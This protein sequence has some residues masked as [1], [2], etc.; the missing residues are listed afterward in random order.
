MNFKHGIRIKSTLMLLTMILSFLPSLLLAETTKNLAVF[1][2]LD[3]NA[4]A[5]YNKIVAEELPKIG[6]NSADPHH[7]VNDQY[8]SKY[9]STILDVLSFL[10]VVNDANVMP[11]FNIDPRLAGFAPFNMLIHKRLDENVT[12]VGHLTPEA[13]LDII[14]ISDKEVREKFIASFKPLNT[15]LDKEFGKDKKSYKTYTSL[16]KDNML[17]F[18]YKFE[19]PEDMDDF[20]DEFQ[21]KFE[22]S[23]INKEYL[24]AGF[25]DFKSTDEG[26][27]ALEAFDIF[28]GYSLCHLEYSYNMFDNKGARPDAGLFAPCTMYMYVK[29]DSDILVV[30]MPKL[31]NIMDTLG[32]KEASRVALVKKLD[33]EIPEILTAFGMK[34]VENVN[35]LKERPKEKFNPAAIAVA[36]AKTTEKI[37][38]PKSLPIVKKEEVVEPKKSVVVKKTVVEEK[39]EASK[40]ET[41]K[42]VVHIE[43]PKVPA[44]PKPL[45]LE[46]NGNTTSTVTNFDRS[47]K[48]SKRVPPN[49]LTSAERYG[50]DGKGTKL[51]QKQGNVGEVDKGRISAYLRAD[52]MDVKH[53]S[54]KLKSAGFEVLAEFPL[55]KKKELVSIVFTDDRLKKMASKTNRGFIGTLRLLVDPK[56]NQISIT[57]PLY[58]GK[59]MLQSDY[60]E[61][62]AK[63]ILASLVK[64]FPNARNSMDKLKYQLLPKYQFM[65]GMPYYNDMEV[66]ARGDDLLEKLEKKKNKKKVVFKFKLPNGSTLIGVKLSKRTSKFPKRIGTNN[67]GM[68]PY[69]ILIENGEAKIMEPKY[70][71]ALMYPQLTMEEFMTIATIPGAIIKDCTKVFR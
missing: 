58:M 23:F 42:R 2:T 31:V 27:E 4:E 66:I 7:R 62:E 19:R 9:G 29:K 71:L 1:Y 26:E 14:G 65:D 61:K 24:I 20:I 37:L 53:A 50:K 60:N 28:W 6:F 39:V 70:Y 8:K 25:H 5:K 38:E 51:T 12:H 49:Y 41:M 18:E 13:M 36:L 15:L 33:R 43:L 63:E 22:M 44:V 56:N 34:A 32:V 30:G 16:S 69:P 40:V 10:P 48:F 35:P 47:I 64:A 59:A 17:N 46:I 57:N 52:L 3:G 45:V 68:L 54:D 21:N 11:L 55:D 67:A